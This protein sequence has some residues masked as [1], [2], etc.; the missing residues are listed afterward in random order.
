MNKSFAARDRASKYHVD[1]YW[2]EPEM[3]LLKINR[4]RAWQG[5]PPRTSLDD[6]ET[7]GRRRP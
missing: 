5:L 2:N 6:A 7:H 3:R 4:A 1:R